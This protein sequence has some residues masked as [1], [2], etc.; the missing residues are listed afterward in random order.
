MNTQNTH[1]PEPIRIVQ[2]MATSVISP[3]AMEYGSTVDPFSSQ[4]NT[5]IE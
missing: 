4:Q 3:F 2:D 5:I 1:F